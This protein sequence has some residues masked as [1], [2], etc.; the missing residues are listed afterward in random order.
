MH[1]V[2][3]RRSRVARGTFAEKTVRSPSVGDFEKRCVQIRGD[4]A[5]SNHVWRRSCPASYVRKTGTLCH[6]R[7]DVV[8][9]SPHVDEPVGRI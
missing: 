7:F 8:Q 6:A 9:P 5:L 2:L 1:L 3:A 4:I